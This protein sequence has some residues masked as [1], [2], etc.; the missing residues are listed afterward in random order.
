MRKRIII[1]EVDGPLS[2]SS[3]SGASVRVCRCIIATTQMLC[4]FLKFYVFSQ[5]KTKYENKN[6]TPTAC[7]LFNII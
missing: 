4:R 3:Q 1:T 2:V 5:T 6:F 7:S